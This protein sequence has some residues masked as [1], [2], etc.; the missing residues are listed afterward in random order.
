MEHVISSNINLHNFLLKLTVCR[1]TNG[2]R[3]LGLVV[4]PIGVAVSV[5]KDYQVEES[6][7]HLW[8]IP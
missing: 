2:Q 7:K 8:D 5:L 6:E 4:K 3:M 1:Q